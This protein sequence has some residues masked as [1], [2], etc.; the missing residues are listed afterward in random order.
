M[1]SEYTEIVT[2]NARN[3][4]NTTEKQITYSLSK[5]GEEFSEAATYVDEFSAALDGSGFTKG[6]AGLSLAGAALLL[7]RRGEET[8]DGDEWKYD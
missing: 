7:T 1:A 3:L 2:E 4:M 5:Y 8:E 6:L